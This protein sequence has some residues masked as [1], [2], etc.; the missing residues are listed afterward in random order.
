MID[1]TSESVQISAEIARSRL[2]TVVHL[3]KRAIQSAVIAAELLPINEAV[4]YGALG[5]ALTTTDGGPLLGA[6]VLGGTTLAVEGSAVMAASGI[7]ATDKSKEVFRQVRHKLR[8]L[9]P[10]E[11]KMGPLMEAG[12]A[13]LGGSV[14]VL[15]EKQRENPD[16]TKKQNIKHGLF[17]AGWMSAYFAGEGAFIAANTEPHNILNARTIGAAAVAVAASVGAAQWARLHH[18]RKNQ[19]PETMQAP[20][21]VEIVAGGKLSPQQ[22]A[23]AVEKCNSYRDQSDEATKI[24]LYGDDVERALSDDRSI[25]VRYRETAGGDTHMPLLVPAAELEWYNMNLLQQTYGQQTEFLYFA[26]PPIPQEESS[27]TVILEAIKTKLDSGAVIITDEYRDKIEAGE[28]LWQSF[29]ND[30]LGGGYVEENLGGGEMLRTAEVFAGPGKVIGSQ[31]IVEAPSIHEIYH[32]AVDSGEIREDIEN[33]VA[34]AT[35]IDGEEAER[36][37]SIYENPFDELSE[38]HPVKAGFDKE[39]LLSILKDP[40]VIKIVNRVNGMISTL[41]IFVGDF[42]HCP[43]FN[44]NYFKQHYPEHFQTNNVFMFPGIVSDESMRGLRYSF[45]VVDMA[46]KLFAKRGSDVLITFECTEISATY[47]PQIVTAAIGNSGVASISSLEA[48]ISTTE[49]KAIRKIISV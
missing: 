23:R 45:D 20:P 46:T 5:Y 44:Q 43:W 18:M 21:F 26:H 14:V 6:A 33:G 29:L 9:I 10:T 19:G 12:V 36:I 15:A 4:R 27:R 41:C 25:L 39:G 30:R 1:P 48:P 32:R 17:T 34:L 31:G 22:V 40:E 35:V 38:G 8:R 16:R 24:G 7:L 49:Y 28:S 3:G 2:A 37:W 47:I 11:S 42:G 13:M